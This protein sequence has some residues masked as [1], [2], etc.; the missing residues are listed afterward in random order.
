[1][2]ILKIKTAGNPVLRQV[3]AK[4]TKV[5]KKIKR[6]LSDMADTMYEADGVGLAAPQVGVSSRIVVIDIGEG[7]IE[8]INPEIICKEGTC[9]NVEGC[10][11]VP[12]F[13]GEVERAK[14]VKVKYQD[15]NG[16]PV[17][18]DATDLLAIAVQH[19]LDHLD[20]ILFID[21]ANALLPKE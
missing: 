2:A 11:S 9:I 10:L 5:D 17:V 1:M 8:M 4:V 7:V 19:E 21:K 18:L 14:S 6:L 3:A 12:N 20:G 13:D 15:R 16:K